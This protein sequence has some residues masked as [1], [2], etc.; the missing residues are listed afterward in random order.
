[1]TANIPSAP[2]GVLCMLNVAVTIEDT[3]TFALE[4]VLVTRDGLVILVSKGSVKIIAMVAA[5][6]I[7]PLALVHATNST[8]VPPVKR[9]SVHT[10]IHHAVN[11]EIVLQPVTHKASANVNLASMV[12][13]ANTSPAL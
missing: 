9:K 3:A 1:M 13:P 4:N 2:N 11:K 6:V 12:M 5:T 10:S 7:Q 8:G